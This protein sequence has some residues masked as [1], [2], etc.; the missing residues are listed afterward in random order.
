MTGFNLESDTA[1]K[2]ED[3]KEAYLALTR[4][5]EDLKEEYERYRRSFD[6]MT[7]EQVREYEDLAYNDRKMG[8][9]NKNSFN[10]DARRADMHK[11][12]LIMINVSGMKTVNERSRKDGDNVIKM[13]AKSLKDTVSDKGSVYRL[14][15]DE[16]GIICG[17]D[18]T[19]CER[20]M[21]D[22]LQKLSEYNIRFVYGIS[23][24][25]AGKSVGQMIEEA[26]TYMRGMRQMNSLPSEERDRLLKIQENTIQ[27]SVIV[28]APASKMQPVIIENDDE[29][30][31]NEIMGRD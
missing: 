10:R 17:F 26:D 24:G 4:A 6:G 29:A 20:V 5:F 3:L 28:E 14:V 25:E 19:G 23:T 7:V 18:K 30:Y 8:V 15:G 13:V 12:S 31:I 2:Y 22:I 1:D 9:K 11:N 21:E 27:Q 16:F